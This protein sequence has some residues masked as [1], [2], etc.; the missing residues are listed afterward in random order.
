MDSRWFKE[1][2]TLPSGEQAKAVKESTEALK[3]S[4]LLIRRL[5]Q[6]LEDEIELTYRLDEDFTNPQWHTSAIA[7]AATRKTLKKVI[8]LLP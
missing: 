4:T 2:R 8:K 1:D 5:T 6:I 7:N 3:N